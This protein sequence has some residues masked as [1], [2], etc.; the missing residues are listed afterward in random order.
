M[1]YKLADPLPDLI[2]ITTHYAMIK[3]SF[4]GA[5]EN[6]TFPLGSSF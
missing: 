1:A 5:Q 3:R 6:H 4:L 2:A